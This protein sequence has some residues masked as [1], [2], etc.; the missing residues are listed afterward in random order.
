[1]KLKTLILINNI[2]LRRILARLCERLGF[3][4]L[5]INALNE[6]TEEQ[7]LNK[8]DIVITDIIF[9]GISPLGHL[10]QLSKSLSYQ[11]LII[12]SEM[13]LSKIKT[14]LAEIER[15]DAYFETPFDLDDLEVKLKAYVN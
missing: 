1:M 5:D 11:R 9:D 8:Y 13:E 10:S 4:T 2:I 6:L 12:V 14:N 3:E 7:A 15:A